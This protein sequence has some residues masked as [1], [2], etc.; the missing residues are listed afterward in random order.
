MSPLPFAGAW[1][2]GSLSGWWLRSYGVKGCLARRQGLASGHGLSVRLCG[3]WLDMRDNF[4]LNVSAPHGA[5][6]V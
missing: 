4:R 1:R 6:D 2:G 5:V 3:G